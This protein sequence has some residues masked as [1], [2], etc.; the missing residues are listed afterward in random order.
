[1]RYL[2]KPDRFDARRQMGQENVDAFF[3]ILVVGC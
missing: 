2:Q 1:L 3:L